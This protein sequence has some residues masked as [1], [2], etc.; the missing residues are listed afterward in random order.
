[1]FGG[2]TTACI[3]SGEEPDMA[4]AMKKYLVPGA[5]ILCVVISL[6]MWILKPIP[7]AHRYDLSFQLS[8]VLAVIW[9][10]WK[11]SPGR[12]FRRGVLAAVLLAGLAFG[13]HSLATIDPQAE[14]VSS[15]R[16]V[17]EAIDGGRNPYTSGTV[18]HRDENGTVV[19][20]N[21]NYPPSEIYPY[22]L[23]FRLS[24]KWNSAILT[25]VM[26]LLNAL[27]C[28]ILLRMF[29][30]IRPG[31]LMAFFPIFLFGEIKTNPSLTFLVTALLLW[32]MKKDRER[33]QKI[34]RY[35]IAV[36]FG[37][38]LMTK[39]LIIPLMAAYYWHKFDRRKFRSLVAI[40]LDTGI[41]LAT[42]V[43]VMAPFGVAAV[44]KNTVLFNLVLKDRAAL[45]TF[46]PNVLSGPLE[47]LGL[48]G[49]YPIAAVIILGLS[50]LAA[51]RLGLFP[52][53]LTAAFTFLLVA[54]TPEPQYLPIILYLTLAARCTDMVEWG[55][56]PSQ[57]LK[58][59][60][61]AGAGLAD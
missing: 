59:P 16:T 8:L 42:A 57:V 26:V 60:R 31:Y 28:L 46:Y 49:V 27:C 14:I 34:T 52:A 45:T 17:F 44:F 48:G 37:I 23:A 10:F 2:G 21:F 38:G 29:P 43:L 3:P 22:Y 9:L 15:Y 54:A 25:A 20:G 47:W 1:V 53:M 40:A 18:F 41:A 50:I 11:V 51:P 4:E 19:Y 55:T 32:L 24:G 56:L 35:L 39:F 6:V 36:V 12:I 33:P 5:L 61:P 58:P 13:I 7:H 30:A